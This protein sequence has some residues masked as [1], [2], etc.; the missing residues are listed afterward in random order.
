MPR[1]RYV[2][3]GYLVGVPAR[4]LDEAEVAA[5]GADVSDL[6]ASGQYVEDMQA[7]NGR[8]RSEVNDGADSVS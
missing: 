6:L 4:D 5:M 2:G 8:K 3:P 1:L 7:V